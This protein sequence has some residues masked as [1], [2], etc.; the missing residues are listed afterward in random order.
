MC[1]K[2][3]KKWQ[4]KNYP[5]FLEIWPFFLILNFTN[6]I[7]K[8]LNIFFYEETMSLVLQT[9]WYPTWKKS[10]QNWALGTL[11]FKLSMQV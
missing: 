5:Y 9:F 8:Q 4:K 1:T 11:W 10:V 7:Q 3:V 2:N 6:P